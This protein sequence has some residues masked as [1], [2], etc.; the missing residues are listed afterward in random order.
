MIWAVIS[1]FADAAV[2]VDI[3]DASEATA[4]ATARFMHVEEIQTNFAVA[5]LAAFGVTLYWLLAI[6]MWP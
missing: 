5:W 1:R 4:R 3:F 6:A 2:K